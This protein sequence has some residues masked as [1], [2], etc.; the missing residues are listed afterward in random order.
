MFISDGGGPQILDQ[1]YSLADT[2]VVPL[3][4]CMEDLGYDYLWIDDIPKM[5]EWF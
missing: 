3:P 5:T 1:F 2:C 4:D